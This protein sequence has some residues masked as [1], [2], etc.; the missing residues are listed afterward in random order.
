MAYAMS[1]NVAELRKL[2]PQKNKLKLVTDND[3][4]SALIITLKNGYAKLKIENM[5]REGGGIN[6]NTVLFYVKMGR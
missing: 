4:N 3:K 1:N 2:L 6:K 5:G